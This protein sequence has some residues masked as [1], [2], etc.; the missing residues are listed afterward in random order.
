[1]AD[2]VLNL[3][4]DLVELA[5][6]LCDTESVSG[7]ERRLADAVDQALRGLDHL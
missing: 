7:D 5:R 4:G 6:A 1:M 3:T 2:P